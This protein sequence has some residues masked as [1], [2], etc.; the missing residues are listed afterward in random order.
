MYLR[1]HNRHSVDALSF[2]DDRWKG[3]T[4]C[5]G[6]PEERAAGKSTPVLDSCGR[7]RLLL[8]VAFPL[9]PGQTS[10][11]SRHSLVP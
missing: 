8:R 3:A 10:G 5:I 4:V 1:R 2:L 9:L 6:H 11:R 7:N